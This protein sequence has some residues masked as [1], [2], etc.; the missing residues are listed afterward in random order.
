M[1]NDFFL[2]EKP[3]AGS[4]ACI[5]IGRLPDGVEPPAGPWRSVLWIVDAA[6][7]AGGEFAPGAV[8]V[9][10]V[11][12]IA[13]AQLEAGLDA[14]LASSPKY[15]PSLYVTRAIP[16]EHEARFAAAIDSVVACMEANHR[17]RV[18]R[19]QDAFAWQSYLFQNASAYAA[20]RLPEDWAGALAGVPA[21]VCGAGPSLDVSVSALARAACGGVVFAADS[22][23]RALSRVG[24]QADFAVS[25]DVAKTPVKCL[26]DP[27]GPA[28]V[29][30]S[31]NSP[32]EWSDAMPAERRYYVSSNQLTLDWF[33]SLGISRTKVAVCEN[34]GATAIELARFLGCSPIYVFGMDLALNAEGALQRHHGAVETSLYANSG[35]NAEQEFPRVPGNFSAEV[36]THVIGDWRALDRRLAGWPAN[37]IWVVTDRGAKLSNTTVVRPEEFALP[38]G[39]VEKE[40]RLRALAQPAGASHDDLHVIAGKLARFGSYLVEWAP[41]LR[42]TLKTAGRD[43][44]VKELRS[45]FATV[46]NG[47][48]LGAYSLKLMP[49]LLPPVDGDRAHWNTIVDELERLGRAAARA[50]A[51]LKG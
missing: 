28:R 47:Q 44:L 37:L 41:F 14:F 32:P 46:E 25:I 18:T 50:A 3:T 40:S 7:A 34:C 6:G 11:D 10:A 2:I 49:H 43:A 20:R 38:G 31:A 45:L 17:S 4:Q 48:M 15:L 27:L 1:P 22:S 35:F 36:P 16:A 9:L 19:Q 21:L 39:E 23:L 24:V 42:K 29:V 30:L 8:S 26:P 13:P 33:A 12:Q 5:L 51:A